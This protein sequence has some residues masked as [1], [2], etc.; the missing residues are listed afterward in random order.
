MVLLT[1]PKWPLMVALETPLSV[2]TSARVGFFGGSGAQP[3]A[4]EKAC[5]DVR[6][7]QQIAAF[8]FG[9]RKPK[10]T[11]PFWVLR[12]ESFDHPPLHPA[13]VP[14]RDVLHQKRQL[15]KPGPPRVSRFTP[16][17]QQSM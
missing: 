6:S 14:R 10:E 16:E 7:V 4:I 9:G 12:L 11:V 8:L 5:T 2:A 3:P 15:G 1:A 17:F 13:G